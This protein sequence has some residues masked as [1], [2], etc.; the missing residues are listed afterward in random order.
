MGEVLADLYRAGSGPASSRPARTLRGKAHAVVRHV[1]MGA[2]ASSGLP[3]QP[4]PLSPRPGGSTTTVY[5][6]VGGEQAFRKLVKEFY[7][8]VAEDPLL[9]PMYPAD[10]LPGAEDRLA[11]FL[12]QYWGGPS[13]YNEQRGHPRLRMRHVP[14]AIGPAERD[15]WLAHMRT[16]LDT[17][18]L[19]PKLDQMI[20]TYLVRA[21]E[22]MRN[23]ETSDPNDA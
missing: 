21:A 5:E 17:L 22:S 1:I 18:D 10:D 13:T 4:V 11:L 14:F 23:R 9:R 8:G 3:Q 6:L 16:A 19:E 15:A 2:M 20:W 12:I 7:K